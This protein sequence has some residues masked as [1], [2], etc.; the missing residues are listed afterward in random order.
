L[1]PLQEVLRNLFWIV[2]TLPPTHNVFD[3]PVFKESF[4]KREHDF[5]IIQYWEIL[6]IKSFQ[7]WNNTLK[8]LNRLS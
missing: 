6:I 1:H 5:W 7:K 4:Q 2:L 3:D 8:R